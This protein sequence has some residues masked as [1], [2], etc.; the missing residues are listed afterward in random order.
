MRVFI[1]R[2]YDSALTLSS[3][4]IALRVVNFRE[5]KLLIFPDICLVKML[6]SE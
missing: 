3:A 6:T 5:I 4:K 1:N 2:D